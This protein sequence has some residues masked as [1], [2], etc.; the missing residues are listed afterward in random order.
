MATL[1][2]RLKQY[3]YEHIMNQ[4][5]LAEKCGVSKMTINS[6]ENGLQE[7]SLLTLAKIEKVIGKQE[8][9]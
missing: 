2:E 5:E 4:K 1:A 6:I 9:E 3:R 8:D 7:P